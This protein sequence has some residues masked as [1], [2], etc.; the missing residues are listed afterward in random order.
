MPRPSVSLAEFH[1]L[2]EPC[3][4]EGFIK[5]DPQR[6]N[7]GTKSDLARGNSDHACLDQGVVP[8]RRRGRNTDVKPF[9]SADPDFTCWIEA[10]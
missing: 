7:P 3:S 8:S 5:L 1:A 4:V 2:W 9:P 6:R 10:A